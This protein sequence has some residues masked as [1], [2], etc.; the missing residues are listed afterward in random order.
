MDNKK[1]TNIKIQ[2]K[3]GRYMVDAEFNVFYSNG[4]LIPLAMYI[5]DKKQQEH[6]INNY[7]RTNYKSIKKQFHKLHGEIA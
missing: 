3:Y 6:T 4:I 2:I 5:D 7:W 1:S